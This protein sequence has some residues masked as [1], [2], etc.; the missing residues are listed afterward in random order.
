MSRKIYRVSKTSDNVNNQT[1]EN[2]I[3]ADFKRKDVRCSNCNHKAF[4]VLEG[5][6]GLI[7]IKCTRCKHII[8]INLATL[9]KTT[10]N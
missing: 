8:T 7:E 2:R 9:S 1:K 4:V 10:D 6:Q 5:S 3:G